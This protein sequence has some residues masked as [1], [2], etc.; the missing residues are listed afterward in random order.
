MF[1]LQEDAE[2]YLVKM[3]EEVNMCAIHGRRVTIQ[4]K[5]ICLWKRVS[6]KSSE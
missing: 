5:D 2:N 4:I 3:F 1:A 6:G